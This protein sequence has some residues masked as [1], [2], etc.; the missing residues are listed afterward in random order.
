MGGPDGMRPGSGTMVLAGV[1]R[2]RAG[3]AMAV[4]RVLVLVLAVRMSVAV[5]LVRAVVPAMSVALV[6]P[7]P[8]TRPPPTQR[9]PPSLH[10]S[11]LLVLLSRHAARWQ[12]VGEAIVRIACPSR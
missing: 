10:I 4:L 2:V 6:V 1:G 11:L 3:V 7:V 9:I 5:P 12:V 8:L